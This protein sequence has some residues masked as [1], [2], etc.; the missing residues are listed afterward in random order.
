MRKVKR[1]NK[2]LTDIV[3]DVYRDMYKNATPY[4]DFDTLFETSEIS[5]DGKKIIHYE[6][7]M[8]DKIMSDEIL[9]HHIV[10]NGLN[11]A[12]AQKLIVSVLLGC[13]PKY[14]NY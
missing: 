7:Y 6:N 12:E 10:K 4:A 8:I 11:E 13:S 5:N 2:K 3:F 9:Q 14:K 1:S